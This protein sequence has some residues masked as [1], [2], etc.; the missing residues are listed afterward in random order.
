MAPGSIRRIY[1]ADRPG[2]GTRKP[3]VRLPP[4]CGHSGY[5]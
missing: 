2:S 3:H 5:A 4:H 1:A